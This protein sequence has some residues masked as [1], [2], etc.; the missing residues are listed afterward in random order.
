[1]SIYLDNAATT[2]ID[3]EVFEAM[4]PYLT[5]NFGN[6]SSTHT[7]GRAAK[8]AIESSR[9]KI[10]QILNA[11]PS[12]IFF[13]SG[14]TESDN[15]AIAG[16]INTF[17]I[18]H[19]ISTKIEHHA[20]LH[21][22]TELQKSNQIEISYLEL[23][24]TGNIDL[25]QLERDLE[26]HQNS[27]VTLMHA[28]N[29]IGN[30]I[31]LERI[32]NLCHEYQSYFHSDTVQTIGKYQF[33]LNELTIHSIAGSAHKFHGP[34][35]IGFLY[36]NTLNRIGP[37]IF[38]GSQE[39]NI[40]PGTENVAGIVG[41]AKAVEVAYTD[42]DEKRKYIS[43]LKAKMI[44]ELKKHMP[45]ILFN[46]TS[47]NLN[48]SLYTVL[49]VNLPPSEKN[50]MILF[51]L[52]L[53]N[54]SVSGGSACGSGALQGSHVINEITKEENVTTIRFSFS[55]YNTMKEIEMVIE[56]LNKLVG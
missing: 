28:N 5:R 38:G 44:R 16:F 14:G 49:S 24:E 23:D 13:T 18:K 31:D 48:E 1:M 15:I 39:R 54:I 2:P 19:V 7:N 53:K 25:G 50:E 30:L 36:L 33:D 56:T 4:V 27:L 43:Q 10:A 35:G 8:S 47:G 34:K 29:E 17:Q 51:Q 41:L 42:L 12:D 46:G 11:S 3:Q 52:D 37:L 6:P 22:L 45:G 40:R 9:K 55:K 26:A 21:T 32:S 20:V